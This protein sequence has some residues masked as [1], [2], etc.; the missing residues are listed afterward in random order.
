MSSDYD[1]CAHGKSLRRGMCIHPSLKLHHVRRGLV[2]RV[3]MIHGDT[4]QMALLTAITRSGESTLYNTSVDLNYSRDCLHDPYVMSLVN[5]EGGFIKQPC[6]STL[7]DSCEC[8]SPPLS[9]V[10]ITIAHFL[11]LM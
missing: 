1:T 8:N 9:Y 10:I 4:S 7:R 11:Y 5:V 3:L 6:S 2:K